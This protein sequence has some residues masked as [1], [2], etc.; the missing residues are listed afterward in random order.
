VRCSPVSEKPSTGEQEQ[1]SE[2]VE[3]MI[4]RVVRGRVYDDDKVTQ[5]TSQICGGIIEQLL[6]LNLFYK[7]AGKG[8]NENEKQSLSAFAELALSFAPRIDRNK[9]ASPPSVRLYSACAFGK[10]MSYYCL[11]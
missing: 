10:H 2:I 9:G 4:C 7:Y 8:E 1:F 11:H 5:L 6:R 3:K